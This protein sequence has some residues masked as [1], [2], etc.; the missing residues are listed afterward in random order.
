MVVSQNGYSAG[1]RSVIYNPAVPGT[2]ILFP[3]GLRKGPAG[4][5][6]LYV[7]AQLHTRVENGAD[8]YGMW[9]Y[10]YRDIR[11]MKLSKKD[12]KLLNASRIEALD[13]LLELDEANRPCCFDNE[14]TLFAASS[15]SN[16][17]SGTAMDWHAPRH[18][19]A[20]VG[21]WNSGQVSTIH[22]IVN[23]ECEG[24]VRWGGDYTGRKDEMH[25]EIISA[26]S[27]CTRILTKLKGSGS[28]TPTAPVSST[29]ALSYT[30][31]KSLMTGDDVK[32]LQRVLNAWYKTAKPIWWPLVE[33]GTFAPSTDT[34]VRYLQAKAGLA[35][36]GV[37]G[38]ATRK[39]LGL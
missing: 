36:D 9:G 3:G 18:P 27:V 2:S 25:F 6:L 21:T 14:D 19:L 33:D 32:T 26:E 39:V 28:V 16:H 1:D 10:A 13:S 4:D 8:A 31:G 30:K 7:A 17:S 20:S 5:L 11:A 12:R 23:V 34:A 35:V 37:V 15:L 22:T 38:T 24:A 29:R